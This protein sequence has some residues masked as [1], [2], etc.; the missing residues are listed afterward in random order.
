M[1]SPQTEDEEIEHVFQIYEN[2]RHPRI[3]AAY[4]EAISRWENVRDKSWVG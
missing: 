4:E 1:A 2:T 3:N